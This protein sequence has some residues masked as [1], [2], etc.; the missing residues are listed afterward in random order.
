M[1]FPK[2][3]Q[4][5]CKA[6]KECEKTSGE[7]TVYFLEVNTD[8]WNGWQRL[9]AVL[10]ESTTVISPLTLEMSL[11][12]CKLQQTCKHVKPQAIYKMFL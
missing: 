4:S 8:D 12:I 3:I 7:I 11:N 10:Y 2:G 9:I 5:A 6:A 1:H